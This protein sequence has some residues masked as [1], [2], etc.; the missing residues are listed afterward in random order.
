MR[1]TKVTAQKYE[2]VQGIQG[3][4]DLKG[5][6]ERAAEGH[7]IQKTRALLFWIR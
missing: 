1:V 7:K 3:F 6:S 5:L 2:A 4:A